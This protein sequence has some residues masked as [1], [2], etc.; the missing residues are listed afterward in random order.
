[1]QLYVNKYEAIYTSQ[2]VQLLIAA[3]LFITLIKNF[4]LCSSTEAGIVIK[5][6][7][8]TILLFL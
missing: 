6:F 5:F 8:K 1:M 2:I 7:A 4:K 3:V